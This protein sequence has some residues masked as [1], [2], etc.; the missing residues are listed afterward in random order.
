MSYNNIDQPNRRR[1]EG[2]EGD[3]AEDSGMSLDS[4]KGLLSD[5]MNSLH[6]LNKLKYVKVPLNLNW[7]W[8]LLFCTK[9]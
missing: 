9:I 7:Y 4:I 2:A 6:Y 5:T 8:P 3:D 1:H